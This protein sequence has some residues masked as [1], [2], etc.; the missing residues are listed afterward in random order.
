MPGNRIAISLGIDQ[1]MR[2]YSNSSSYLVLVF[3]LVRRVGRAFHHFM[4]WLVYNN[5][6]L[7]L[8]VAVPL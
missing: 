3:L 7:E 6:A 5:G 8:H 4:A 1:F 2:V